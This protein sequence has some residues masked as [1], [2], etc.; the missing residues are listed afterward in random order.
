MQWAPRGDAVTVRIEIVLLKR[1]D[2]K[3]EGKKVNSELCEAF[4]WKF[5]VLIQRALLAC[6]G[7]GPIFIWSA[8]QLLYTVK[9]FVT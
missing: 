8:F 5:L 4:F 2:K 3:V 9:K 6:K 7:A 1:K